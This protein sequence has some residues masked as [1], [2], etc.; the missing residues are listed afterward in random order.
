M[1][2]F[3]AER[4]LISYYGRKDLGLGCLRNHTDGGDGAS[5]AVRS[6]I[7]KKK[8][9]EA[10]KGHSVSLTTR[11]KIAKARRLIPA[12]KRMHRKHTDA[13][14]LKMKAVWRKT[15]PSFSKETRQKLSVSLTGNKNAIGGKKV[16]N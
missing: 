7:T 3:E 12:S 13:E 8:L 16:W 2:A 9:S 6:L 15:H 10:L 4:F 5:G 14:K 11:Q 1:D